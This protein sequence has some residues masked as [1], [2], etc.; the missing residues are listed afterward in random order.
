MTIESEFLSLMPSTV[1][2]Y[3]KTSRD[4]YGKA[5]FSASG[6]AVRCRVQEDLNV[7][8]SMDKTEM[9]ESGVVY[10]YGVVNVG[11]DDKVVLPSGTVAKVTQ[12]TTK[13]DQIGAHHTVIRFGPG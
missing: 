3:P 4:A 1:V 9:F 11:A 10:C 8:A 12:V 2:I 5:S 13:D 6:T 7:T